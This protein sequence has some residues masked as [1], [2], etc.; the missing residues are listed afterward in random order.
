MTAA[1]RQAAVIGTGHS[2]LATRGTFDLAV[3]GK[4][5]VDAALQDAGLAISDIHGLATYGKPAFPAPR[6]ERVNALGV[7]SMQELLRAPNLRWFCEVETG[8]AMSAVVEAVDAIESGRCDVVVVWRAMALPTGRYG[9]SSPTLAQGDWAFVAPY[10]ATSLLPWH[11]L[12]YARYLALYGGDERGLGRL[13]LASHRYAE[14]NPAAMHTDRP[15]DLDDYLASPYVADPL[16]RLDCDRPVAGCAAVVL[17]SAEVARDAMDRPAFIAAMV[18]NVR[19]SDPGL[20]YTLGVEHGAGERVAGALWSASGETP[21]TIDVAQLYDGFGPTLLYWLEALGFCGR[22]EAA[23]WYDDD[24][25]SPMPVNTFG[26]SLGEGR[27]HGMGHLIA[28][29]KQVSSRAGSSQVDG[30]RTSVVTIGSPLINGG[31][32]VLRAE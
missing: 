16:R 14:L 12:V 21:A 6:V 10:G 11:A 4:S 15:A 25:V 8:L 1:T 24:G 23:N 32:L 28:G 31:A 2:A 18:Q 3:L 30:C 17:A 20:H 7:G 22:G 29:A 13:I 5:A 26:G 9:E 27:L 19:V